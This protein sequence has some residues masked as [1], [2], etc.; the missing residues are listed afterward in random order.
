MR[1]I[2]KVFSQSPETDRT[3]LG[4][5][6]DLERALSQPFDRGKAGSAQPLRYGIRVLQAEAIARKRADTDE[7]CAKT[8]HGQREQCEEITHVFTFKRLPR[9]STGM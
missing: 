1:E 3:F 9:C 4:N 2:R 7:A 6:G 8:V 5:I